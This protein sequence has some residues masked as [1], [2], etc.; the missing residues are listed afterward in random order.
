MVSGGEALAAALEEERSGRRA[1]LVDGL[2]RFRRVAW[3][4]ELASLGC[5]APGK[6]WNF[7]EERCR[8]EVDAHPPSLSSGRSE[9]RGADRVRIQRACFGESI[10]SSSMSKRHIC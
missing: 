5:G 4:P 2:A 6:G 3:E 10:L 7:P 9:T 8:D 1:L